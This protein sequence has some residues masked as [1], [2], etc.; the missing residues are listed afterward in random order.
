MRSTLPIRTTRHPRDMARRGQGE[1]LIDGCLHTSSGSGNADGCNLIIVNM[2]NG[3]A[4]YSGF[5][6]E[7]HT[8][9][10]AQEFDS[11][12]PHA[13]RQFQGNRLGSQRISSAQPAVV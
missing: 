3:E 13:I 5:E 9:A 8:H 4:E 6:P 7:G 11:L 1:L 12:E 2:G 10:G